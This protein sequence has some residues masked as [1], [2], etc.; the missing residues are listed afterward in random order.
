MDSEGAL[1]RLAALLDAAAE[2][3][4]PTPRELAEVL[5]FARQLSDDTETPSPN[6]RT[7]PARSEPPA[8]S[9]PATPLPPISDPPRVPLH[10]PNANPNPDPD[11]TQPTTPPP[12]ETQP[13][14]Q[15][16]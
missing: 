4:G 11:P 10:L 1:A 5:W 6:S 13:P 15:P 8:Q 7:P 14:A 9:D 12:A 3:T 2:G 16:P